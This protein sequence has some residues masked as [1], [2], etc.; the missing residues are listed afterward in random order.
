VTT[1]NVAIPSFNVKEYEDVDLMHP[2]LMLAFLS[3]IRVVK[4]VRV[5]PEGIS[6]DAEI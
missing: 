3:F 2:T 5:F 4:L 1:T 6:T